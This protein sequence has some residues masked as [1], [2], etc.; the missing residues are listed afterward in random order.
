MHI[1]SRMSRSGWFGGQDWVG[2]HLVVGRLVLGHAE[3]NGGVGG[4]RQVILRTASKDASA[5][6]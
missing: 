4:S 6:Y 2:P 5:G 3:P 1:D